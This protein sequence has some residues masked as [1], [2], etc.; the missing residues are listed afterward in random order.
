MTLSDALLVADGY[1]GDAAQALAVLAA[2]VRRL[3]ALLDGA[4]ELASNPARPGGRREW[5]DIGTWLYPGDRVLLM[6]DE[7]A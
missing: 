3:H 7:Q 2:E 1:G 5:V 6:D 4:D